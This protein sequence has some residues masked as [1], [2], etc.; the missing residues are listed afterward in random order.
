M[1]II[2]NIYLIAISPL[3]ASILCLILRQ[4]STNFIISFA[5]KLSLFV[6]ILKILPDFFQHKNIFINNPHQSNLILNFN[7]NIFGLSIILAILFAKILL[8]VFFKEYI[9]KNNLNQIIKFNVSN[10]IN[11]FAI[12]LIIFSTNFINLFIGL[13]IYAIS[14]IIQNSA[15]S[16]NQTQKQL[17][18]TIFNNNFVSVI[19]LISLVII[20]YLFTSFD[21]LN[22]KN[23][24]AKDSQIATSS[25]TI[26]T[27]LFFGVICR[28]FDF[29]SY[30][31]NIKINNQAQQIVLFEELF[32]KLIL[33]IYLIFKISNIFHFNIISQIN[34]YLIY[35]LS[36]FCI[37]FCYKFLK[38]KNLKAI[39]IYFV[40]GHLILIIQALLIFNKEA[41]LSSSYFI[42]SLSISTLII[43][44][45]I[46]IIINYVF[47][48]KVNLRAEN[49]RGAVIISNLFNICFIVA[50]FAPF[51]LFFL[52][53]YYL[54]KSAFDHNLSYIIIAAISLIYLSIFKASLFCGTSVR[55]KI[56]D[57]KIVKT[58]LRKDLINLSIFNYSFYLI[59]IASLL[60]L[61]I[62]LLIYSNSLNLRLIDIS[63]FILNAN[64]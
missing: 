3:L 21:F 58:I 10:L 44:I 37:Y 55:K 30:F 25:I 26:F 13:E 64:L 33:G 61:N 20:H 45:S 19:L 27:I 14:L 47:S 53:N 36:V 50:I 18:Q 7:A 57:E 29:W 46:I 52:G 48:G 60:I 5:L 62:L 63:H 40:L 34:D 24:I 56:I 28:F 22:I 9:Y 15:I 38:Q 41:I 8:L 23:I 35:S 16:K 49:K 51:N 4:K 1:P 11:I 17:Y 42:L 6:I 12:L 54:I 32:I 2:S 31:N 59:V 39:I 43:F